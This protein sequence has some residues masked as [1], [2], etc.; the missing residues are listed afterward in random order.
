MN[1]GDSNIN[2]NEVSSINNGIGSLDIVKEK[3]NF[4]DKSILLHFFSTNAAFFTNQLSKTY[5]KLSNSIIL[6]VDLDDQSS[7]DN[8][9]FVYNKISEDFE[10]E[11]I[12]IIIWNSSQRTTSFDIAFDRKSINS[13][14]RLSINLTQNRNST[15]DIPLK[16]PSS[17]ITLTNS[18]L[19]NK[20]AKFKAFVKIYKIPLLQISTYLDISMSNPS[21]LH[22]IGFQ[23]LNRI[24]NKHPQK[25]NDLEKQP[26]KKKAKDLNQPKVLKRTYSL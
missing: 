4:Y 20:K 3:V 22:F 17:T 26:L 21:F 2:F 7:I 1:Y 11:K 25:C 10:V 13:I 16:K 9:F 18:N 8:F 12:S 24:K 23:L 14:N 5:F 19:N 15:L 6:L